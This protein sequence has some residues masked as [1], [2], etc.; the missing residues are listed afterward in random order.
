MWIGNGPGVDMDLSLTKC[1]NLAPTRSMA[2]RNS[3]K[4][5]FSLLSSSRTLNTRL[6]VAM[7]L[8]RSGKRFVNCS[9]ARPPGKSFRKPSYIS[10]ISWALCFVFWDNQRTSDSGSLWGTKVFVSNLL[11]FMFYLDLK[12]AHPIFLI[13]ST[14]VCRNFLTLSI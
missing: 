1:T 2:C 4:P 10:S 8:L 13:L 12:A 5:S 11:T 9:M 14:F 6:A 3:L 7:P